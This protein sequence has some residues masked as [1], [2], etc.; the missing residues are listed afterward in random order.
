MIFKIIYIVVLASMERR[1]QSFR[2]AGM[3][4][5]LEVEVFLVEAGG[6]HQCALVVG[7][8][9]CCGLVAGEKTLETRC[10]CG[11]RLEVMQMSHIS[12]EHFIFCLSAFFSLFPLTPFC[13]FLSF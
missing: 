4:S 12:Q 10:E 9:P 3:K 2:R 13:V 6:L 5:S 1:W 11:P 8:Q 7:G